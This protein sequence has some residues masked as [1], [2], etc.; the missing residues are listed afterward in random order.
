M[1]KVKISNNAKKNFFAEIVGFFSSG[2]GHFFIV[3]VVFFFFFFAQTCWEDWKT[4]SFK[5]GA[6]TVVMIFIFTLDL[7]C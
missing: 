5:I 6:D 7:K 2:M 3:C 1:V 4:N